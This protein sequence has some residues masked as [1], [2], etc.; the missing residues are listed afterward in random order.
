M[1]QGRVVGLVERAHA[2]QEK[3]MQLMAG[4]TIPLDAVGCTS[5]AN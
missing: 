3:I 1:R 4:R 5:H 2:T